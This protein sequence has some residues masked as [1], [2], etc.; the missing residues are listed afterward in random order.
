MYI[1]LIILIRNGPMI[2]FHTCS[3]IFHPLIQFSY[4]SA[5]F[6]VVLYSLRIVKS[7]I[8]RLL[9]YCHWKWCQISWVLSNHPSAYNSCIRCFYYNFPSQMEIKKNAENIISSRS[10]MS[11][12]HWKSMIANTNFVMR[13]LLK[14]S[15]VTLLVRIRNSMTRESLQVEA[16]ILRNEKSQLHSKDLSIMR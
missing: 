14:I 16:L 6:C 7:I 10:W 2:P 1:I 9:P 13:F 4:L 5:H 3:N 11:G 15:G 12:N 8:N